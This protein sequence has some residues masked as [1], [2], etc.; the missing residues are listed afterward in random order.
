VLVALEL[1][2]GFGVERGGSF[3]EGFLGRVVVKVGTLARAD[4]EAVS[5]RQCCSNEMVQRKEELTWKS[6]SLWRIRRE[7]KVSLGCYNLREARRCVG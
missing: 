5:Q 2:N 1:W 7:E 4:D 3:P 6:G